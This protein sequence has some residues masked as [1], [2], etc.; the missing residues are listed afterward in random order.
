S[1]LSTGQRDAALALGAAR[2]A[3]GGT[4][5]LERRRGPPPPRALS[6]AVPGQRGGQ[7]CRAQALGGGGVVAAQKPLLRVGALRRGPGQGPW[8]VLQAPRPLPVRLPQGHRA[9]ARRTH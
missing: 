9:L 6:Q 2:A 7:R 3:G 1:A 8:G 4:L 5:L